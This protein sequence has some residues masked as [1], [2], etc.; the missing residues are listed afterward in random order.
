MTSYALMGDREK[1][2]E[3][4]CAKSLFATEREEKNVFCI[5]TRP[6]GHYA[7]KTTVYGNYR[8]FHLFR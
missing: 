5:K 3:K 6:G 2:E 8:H 7:E 4:G 1:A